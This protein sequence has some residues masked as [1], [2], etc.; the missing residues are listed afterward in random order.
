MNLTFC[1]HS[2]VKLMYFRGDVQSKRCISSPASVLLAEPCRPRRRAVECGIQRGL[3][4]ILVGS[5]LQPAGWTAY[6]PVWRRQLHRPM[7]RRQACHRRLPNLPAL[8]LPPRPVGVGSSHSGANKGWLREASQKPQPR[9]WQ[10]C[11][12]DAQCRRRSIRSVTLSWCAG[13]RLWRRESTSI[14]RNIY[15]RGAVCSTCS[16]SHPPRT[17]CLWHL[18]PRGSCCS[19]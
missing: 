15:L 13:G 18:L 17:T 6:V 16:M 2:S 10:H 12:L 4:Q 5:T 14:Y 7:R 19:F 1:M 3:C 8:S 9:S 11:A